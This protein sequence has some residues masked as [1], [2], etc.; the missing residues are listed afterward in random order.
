MAEIKN[1]PSVTQDL[2]RHRLSYDPLTGIFTHLNPVSAKTPKGS[3]AGN[4]TTKIP[5]LYIGINYKRYAV[6]RLAWMYMY[7]VWPSGQIDHI[8]G[9]GLDNRISN[10]RDATPSQ[11][12]FNRRLAKNNKSGVK[13]LFWL[14]SKKKWRACVAST[15]EGKNG[16][17]GIYSCRDDAIKAIQLGRRLIHGEFSNDG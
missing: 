15:K 7:G 12:Q 5:Y 3:V 10:L 8:N 11:N 4:S 13:G 16:Y 17:L 1:D 14:E 9:N 2:L 6:H